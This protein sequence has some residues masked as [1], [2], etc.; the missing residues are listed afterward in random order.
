M[1]WDVCVDVMCELMCDKKMM[2]TNVVDP[3]GKSKAQC[4]VKGVKCCCVSKVSRPV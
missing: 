1:G 3:D 4:V 2:M